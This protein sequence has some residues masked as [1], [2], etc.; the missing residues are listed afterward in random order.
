MTKH[1]VSISIERSLEHICG[2]NWV[3]SAGSGRIIWI[4]SRM[5]IV[6]W[7][8]SVQRCIDE[9]N[10]G[11]N[12]LA[13]GESHANE[14]GPSNLISLL[15]FCSGAFE[16]ML[17]LQPQKRKFSETLRTTSFASSSMAPTFGSSQDATFGSSTVNPTQGGNSKLMTSYQR[18]M[19]T[20]KVRCQ[21]RQ[22]SIR[23]INP[24]IEESHDEQQNTVGHTSSMSLHAPPPP[25]P[26]APAAPVASPPFEDRIGAAKLTISCSKPLS[27]HGYATGSL[28][29]ISLPKHFDGPSSNAGSVSID[30]II[31]C[32]H[33]RVSKTSTYAIWREICQF[34]ELA[35]GGQTWIPSL[36]NRLA[37]ADSGGKIICR[38]WIK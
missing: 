29:L 4:S 16:T 20:A 31:S 13:G 14:A 27:R 9:L 21:S 1:K 19:H 22:D 17:P 38:G 10:Q 7:N 36:A 32:L 37:H 8:K 33:S 23:S 11:T 5:D 24:G 30:C 15:F 28:R 12:S 3:C 18:Y 35:L 34:V 6:N 2:L 25:A 26:A